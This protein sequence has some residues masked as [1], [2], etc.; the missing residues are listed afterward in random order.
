LSSG[1]GELDLTGLD[2]KAEFPSSLDI[3]LGVWSV[4]E[5][6]E[7]YGRNENSVGDFSIG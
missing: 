5:E 2:G 4:F 7:E 1:H 3:L 6:Y